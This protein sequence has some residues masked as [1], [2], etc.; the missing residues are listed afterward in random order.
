MRVL[1]SQG[2]AR[3][4]PGRGGRAALA[5]ADEDVGLVILDLGL[6]DIDGIDVCR[7]P[8]RRAARTWRS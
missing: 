1:D 6:P 3:A 2:Y 5:A 4:P 8:A 7:A